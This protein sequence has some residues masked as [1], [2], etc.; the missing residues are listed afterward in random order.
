MSCFEVTH[1]INGVWGFVPNVISEFLLN[2]EYCLLLVAAYDVEVA[3]DDVLLEKV[4]QQSRLTASVSLDA[5][6]VSTELMKRKRMVC[7][8]NKVQ[9]Q[10]VIIFIC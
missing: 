4:V 9:I 7:R 2:D 6:Y 8:S 5:R 10:V 1:V 3:C